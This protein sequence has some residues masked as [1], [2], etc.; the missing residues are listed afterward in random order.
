MRTYSQEAD[1]YATFTVFRPTQS[2]SPRMSLQ[3]ICPSP[4][5]LN[6]RSVRFPLANQ[7]SFVL[8]YC[9]A[10]MHKLFAVREPTSKRD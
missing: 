4:H 9:K 7:K 10:Q 3:Q 2:Q 5:L 6:T 8:V 1:M